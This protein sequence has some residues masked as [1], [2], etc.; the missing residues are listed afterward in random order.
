MPK[1]SHCVA[2]LMVVCG[3]AAMA[4]AAFTSQFSPFNVHSNSSTCNTEPCSRAC[5]ICCAHFH[6]GP[7]ILGYDNCEL[8]CR[9]V[10]GS[11]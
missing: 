7:G 9:S 11:C 5:R 1:I 10:G 8:A 6:G 4:M 2:G 3:S